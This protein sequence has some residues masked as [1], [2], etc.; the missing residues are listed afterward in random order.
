[1]RLCGLFLASFDTSD[2]SRVVSHLATVNRPGANRLMTDA[3]FRSS[4]LPSD[5]SC[6]V[7]LSRQRT[8]LSLGQQGTV[9][10][11][12]VMFVEVTP[13]RP[14]TMLDTMVAMP[15]RND[16]Y[17]SGNVMCMR[18]GPIGSR[19][20]TGRTHRNKQKNRRSCFPMFCP[21]KASSFNA[22]R[23][24]PSPR[25]CHHSL[26]RAGQCRE[27][28]STGHGAATRSPRRARI[29]TRIHPCAARPASKT[30]GGG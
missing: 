12:F 3:D 11:P 27:Y 28:E 16:M 20:R 5:M 15:H 24:K 29:R 13:L 23:P 8:N 14:V 7:A 19:S 6:L 18:I 17:V 26:N 4:L 22:A 21:H 9:H 25:Y 2:A 1:M 30:S 10:F